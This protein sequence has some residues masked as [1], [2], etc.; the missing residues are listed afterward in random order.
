MATI[1][2]AACS[3][4]ILRKLGV[5][6]LAVGILVTAAFPIQAQSLEEFYASKTITLIVA[7]TPKALRLTLSLTYFPIRSSDMNASCGMSTFPTRFIRFL[8][9]RCF[10]SSF[11]LRVTSPP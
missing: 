5:S 4:P 9:S 3:T 2:W 6:V 10:S 1:R 8:P 11:R 7:G